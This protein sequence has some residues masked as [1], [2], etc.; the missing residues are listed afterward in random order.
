MSQ[1][2]QDKHEKR[3]ESAPFA[4]LLGKASHAT[5]AG[6]LQRACRP[7]AL[8]LDLCLMPNIADFRT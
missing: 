8:Q 4:R 5:P 3:R 6:R 1:G 7:G 2:P